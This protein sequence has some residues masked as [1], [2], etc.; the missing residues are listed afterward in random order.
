MCR[1]GIQHHAPQD[2]P[3]SFIT[4]TAY[5]IMLSGLVVRSVEFPFVNLFLS[6]DSDDDLC[7]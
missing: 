4:L 5:F 1:N 3:E 7:V 2:D 6:M